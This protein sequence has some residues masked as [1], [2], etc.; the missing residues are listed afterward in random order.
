MVGGGLEKGTSCLVTGT[1]GAGKS[2][3][4]TVYAM[5]AAERGE[6]SVIFCFDEGRETFLRRSTGL[7]IPIT[8]YVDQQLVAVRQV[9]VS[10]MPPGEF[11]HVV[12]RAVDDHDVK[13]VVID[14]LSGYIHSMPTA[15][16]LAVQLHELLS[17]LSQRGVLTFLILTVHGVSGQQVTTEVDA[18]YLADTVILMR[19]FEAAGRIRRCISVVKKRHGRHETTIRELMMGPTGIQIGPV[20]AEFSGVLTGTP[21]YHGTS[22]VLLSNRSGPAP[23]GHA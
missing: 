21:Q 15:Q 2:T 12:R 1:T 17:Y 20:L 4:A 19:H 5:A 14:S 9:D 3:L 11:S 23:E 10:E 13:I 22:D 18:S 16:A 8:R 6:R 7:G